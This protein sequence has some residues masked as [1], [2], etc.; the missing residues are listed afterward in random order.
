[1]SSSELGAILLSWTDLPVGGTNI[2]VQDL[3]GTVLGAD[4]SPTSTSTA[5]CRDVPASKVIAT[6]VAENA[7]KYPNGASFEV[8]FAFASPSAAHAAFS[9]SVTHLHR[10]IDSSSKPNGGTPSWLLGTLRGVGDEAETVLSNA[11]THS[12]VV[13]AR[14]GEVEMYLVLGGSLQISTEDVA[15]IAVGRILGNTD[16]T[17]VGQIQALHDYLCTGGGQVQPPTFDSGNSP[18]NLVQASS[19]AGLSY[20]IPSRGRRVIRWMMQS[21]VNIQTPA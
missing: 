13:I 1:M 21:S 18:Y 20:R 5:S 4:S 2:P 9:V 16:E 10:C 3:A 15:R 7:I 8:L 14:L 12:S 17:V 19:H 11:P 6:T